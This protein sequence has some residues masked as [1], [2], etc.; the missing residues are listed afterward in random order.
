MRKTLLLLL[1]LSLSIGLSAQSFDEENLTG[2]W[3][4][5]QPMS[6][7][8]DYLTSIDSIGFG[9]TVWTFY[10]Q[11]IE[12]QTNEYSSGVLFSIWNGSDTPNTGRIIDY[13]ITN[14]D[15]LHIT[16]SSEAMINTMEWTIMFK[17]IN[18]TATEMT[19]EPFGS[20]NQI[21]FKKVDSF[22]TSISSPSKT[23]VKGK[24]L[25]YNEAGIQNS[26][27]ER[28]V[29]IVKLGDGTVYKEISK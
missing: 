2:K 20:E 22:T 3:V 13:A 1:S 14:G 4:R 18:L 15:K 9:T 11:D 6:P 25:Y 28:G 29:N 10:Y 19:L 23:G 8:D 21:H 27:P 16:V 17:I 12:H 5:T 24:P 26:Q 7:I